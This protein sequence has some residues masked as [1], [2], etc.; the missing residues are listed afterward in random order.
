[1]I[2]E[3]APLWSTGASGIVVAMAAGAI[4]VRAFTRRERMRPEWWH[5]RG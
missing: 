5:D 3:D 1:M 2:A 4:A